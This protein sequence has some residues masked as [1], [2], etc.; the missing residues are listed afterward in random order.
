[1][2]SVTVN[3]STNSA[4]EEAS[5]LSFSSFFPC[6]SAISSTVSLNFLQS[7]IEWQE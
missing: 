5:S 7:E 4:A 2:A 6:C 3:F 1:L